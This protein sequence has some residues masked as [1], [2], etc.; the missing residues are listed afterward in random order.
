MSIE[1]VAQAAAPRKARSLRR[2]PT[3]SLPIQRR[4]SGRK[5]AHKF[6]YLLNGKKIADEETVSR[7]NALAVPPAYV[8]VRYAS[9][10][11]AHIQAIG[12]DG[13]GRLQYR[14]HAEW[15][16]I[17]EARK[18]RHL[19]RLGKV[20]PR[21]RRAFARHLKGDEPTRAF[22]CT[23]LIELIASSGIRPGNEEYMRRHGSRG[24]ATLLKSDLRIN[25]SRITLSFRAKGGKDIVKELRSPRLARALNV[26]RGLPG[27]RLFQFRNGDG[28]ARTLSP[29]DANEFLRETAGVQ[30]SLKDFRTL[31]ASARVVSKLARIKPEKKPQARHKQVL[32][33]VKEA[34]DDLGNTPT[35]CR[36]S[37]VPDVI[38]EAFERGD[39]DKLA[40]PKASAAAEQMVAKIIAKD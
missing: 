21:L 23:A 26:I 19:V 36:K 33:A 5:G 30:I 29:R 4:R 31:C 20:M 35:I 2:V 18:A 34:A 15:E 11:L 12:R 24:A 40:P 39:L 16:K 27:E 32:E 13:A 38:V 7:L 8:D 3:D 6:D 14:Y 28:E 37:Y 9:D 22:A 1:P 17:R 25:G 10:P